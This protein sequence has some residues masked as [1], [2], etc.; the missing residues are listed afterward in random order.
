MWTETRTGLASWI[1]LP[2]LQWLSRR[3]Y[4]ASWCRSSLG[5]PSDR[6]GIAGC[7][8]RHRNRA[9]PTIG[10]CSNCPARRGPHRPTTAIATRKCPSRWPTTITRMFRFFLCS[11]LF[12]KLYLCQGVVPKERWNSQCKHTPCVR[13]CMC[14]CVCVYWTHEKARCFRC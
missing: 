2:S 9:Q 4:R 10:R 1:H 11:S 5:T 14:V 3:R 8:D 12:S 6:S 7:S 13:T